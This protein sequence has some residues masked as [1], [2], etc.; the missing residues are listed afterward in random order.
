[1]GIPLMQCLAL[2]ARPEKYS[3]MTRKD[4]HCV[5]GGAEIRVREL[6]SENNAFRSLRIAHD[7]I[8]GDC[9]VHSVNLDAFAY[10]HKAQNF[11]DEGE[12]SVLRTFDR[13]ARKQSAATS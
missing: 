12:F 5:A 1:M 7:D 6:R 3:G 9:V 4:F 10:H 13:L 8:G 2:R 11:V